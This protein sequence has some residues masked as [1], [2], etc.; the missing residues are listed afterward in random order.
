MKKNIASEQFQI[1]SQNSRNRGKM[2]TPNTHIKLL[3]NIYIYHTVG[4][5]TKSNQKII[6]KEKWILLTQI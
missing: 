2:D 1:Q 6:E 3:K 5:V 4:A